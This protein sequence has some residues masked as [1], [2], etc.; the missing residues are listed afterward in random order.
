M[1]DETG[2][3]KAN[4]MG[5]LF[6]QLRRE[7]GKVPKITPPMSPGMVAELRKMH[8][9]ITTPRFPEPIEI[10]IDETPLGR[11]ALAS[12]RTADTVDRMTALTGS[13][14]DLAEESLKLSESARADA[15]RS[16]RF[17][18]R[19]AWASVVIAGSSL[20]AAI[21]AIVTSAMGIST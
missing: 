15:A 17:A 14:V 18:K 13:I 8:V 3:R 5:D 9:E 21:V 12:E 1:S 4:S 11:A 7:A 10:D 20:A 19:M 16:E 6:E 2:A